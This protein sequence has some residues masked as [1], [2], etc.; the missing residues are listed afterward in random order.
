MLRSPTLIP[1][2]APT[3]VADHS[4][5]RLFSGSAN[6]PL[7]QEVA[8][9]LGMELGPMIRKRFAD[10][11]LYIQIQESIR[12]CDVFLIQPTCQPVNDHLMELMIMI[13]ACR[14]AS[15]RQITA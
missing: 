11:E 1:Q 14:R 2:P 15:A 8:H 5:L 7:S 12:G 9:S 6:I 4:R 10:G 13:D 3:A